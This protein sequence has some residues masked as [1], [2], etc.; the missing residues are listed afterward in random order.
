MELTAS[1]K[2]VFGFS[3]IPIYLGMAL[4]VAGAP[5]YV[6]L[7]AVIAV[8][9]GIEYFYN[10]VVVR[11]IAINHGSTKAIAAWIFMQVLILGFVY[12]SLFLLSK[13]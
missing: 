6:W 4:I 12:G 11:V 5:L 1:K 9:G 13:T 2:W 7:V 10:K 3:S 8:L